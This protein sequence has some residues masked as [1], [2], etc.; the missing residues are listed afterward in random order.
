ML[1]C[2]SNDRSATL[3]G[4]GQLKAITPPA[5]FEG[6]RLL[7]DLVPSLRA[8]LLIGAKRESPGLYDVQREGS[9]Q[10]F[11]LYDFEVSIARMLDGRRTVSKLIESA[12]KIGIPVTLDSLRKF[13]RQLHA[14]G[15]LADA[16]EGTGPW[17]AR[18]EWKPEVRELYQSALRTFR[19]ERFA[20]ARKYLEALQQIEP[21]L[22]DAVEMLARIQERELFGEA[23]NSPSFAELHGDA[24]LI[25]DEG[26]PK[27]SKARRAL[28]AGVGLCAIAGVA[29]VPVPYRVTSAARLAPTTAPAIVV[30]PRAGKIQKL[31]VAKGAWVE[32]GQPIARLATDELET[33]KAALDQELAGLDHQLT[34]LTEA[35]QRKSAERARGKLEKKQH[36][37]ASLNGKRAKAQ[38]HP[39]AL[40]Q[41]ERRIAKAQGEV[42]KAQAELDKVSKTAELARTRATRDA[43]A[44]QLADLKAQIAQSQITAPATGEFEP[45]RREG[46]PV[47]DAI[48]TVADT[49]SLEATLSIAER[50][51]PR[52]KA[53]MQVVFST[54]AASARWNSTI[55]SVRPQPSGGVALAYAHLANSDRKLSAS[56]TGVAEI[57]CGQVP[58]FS[59]LLGR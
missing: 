41:L 31:L 24:D 23:P 11:N 33:K 46:D 29:A 18:D 14:Y 42:E 25:D 58:L 36:A 43:R 32:K 51:L 28:L 40:A 30:V 21:D 16:S 6:P 12:S 56:T 54:D 53:G 2:V 55:T 48:G 15:F 3:D 4:S 34:R 47:V 17:P 1:L 57:D 20:E 10:V 19:K 52:V 38:S 9:E 22:P 13:L 8:D 26:K 49:R 35:G 59:R 37:L 5:P 45:T 44:Q 39:R 50:D 27:V 7:S